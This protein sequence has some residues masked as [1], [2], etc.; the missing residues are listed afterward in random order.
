MRAESIAL[1]HLEGLGTFSPWAAGIHFLTRSIDEHP[2]FVEMPSSN[3]ALIS[4]DPA[5]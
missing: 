5:S 3:I 4:S 2:P 1:A